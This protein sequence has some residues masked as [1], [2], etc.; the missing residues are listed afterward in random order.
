M[1]S[2]GQTHVNSLNACC[3]WPKTLPAL[4]PSASKPTR[5]ELF[6]VAA[7]EISEFGFWE[8]DTYQQAQRLLLLAKDPASFGT[9]REQADQ[10]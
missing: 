1:L 8:H 7:I 10:G 3:C 6:H 2:G 9:E 4:A 5:G